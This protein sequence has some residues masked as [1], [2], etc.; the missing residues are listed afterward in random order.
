LVVSATSNDA[1]NREWEEH[2]IKQFVA[3][4]C[5]QEVG[6][7]KEVLRIASKYPANHV[8][9]IGD[10]PGDFQAA[11]ANSALFF[12]INPGAEEASW[13]KLYNEGIDRCLAGT[14]AGDYQQ[15]LLAEFD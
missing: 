5:G 8:I 10:A 7:K 2:D 1:L 15:A 9:M 4:I 14:F 3:D 13:R 12:P 6:T 11:V